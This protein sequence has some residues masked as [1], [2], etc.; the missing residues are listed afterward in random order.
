MTGGRA[1]SS[2]RRSADG[3]SSRILARDASEVVSSY[4]KLYYKII[5]QRQ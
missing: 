3:I 5:A 1:R 2:I 4:Y